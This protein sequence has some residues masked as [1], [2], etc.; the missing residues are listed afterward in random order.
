M[1]VRYPLERNIASMNITSSWYPHMV[2][3]DVPIYSECAATLNATQGERLI[4]DAKL[5][6]GYLKVNTISR[7][8]D[9][10]TTSCR[11]TFYCLII[12]SYQEPLSRNLASI[13][14]S[15]L[16]KSA[17]IYSVVGRFN[18]FRMIHTWWSADV[19]I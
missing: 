17:K 18:G 12:F 4:L 5:G 19:V 16:L 10:I 8:S 13:V 11:V 14:N 6:I 1:P 15:S 2:A 9:R 3:F 7:V